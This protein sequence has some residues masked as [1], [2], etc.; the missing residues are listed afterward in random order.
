L[1]L[2]SQTLPKIQLPVHYDSNSLL[3]SRDS[4]TPVTESKTE[5]SSRSLK[6]RCPFDFNESKSQICNDGKIELQG[7]DRVTRHPGLWS[8]GLL[9]LGS[10][11]LS[12]SAPARVWMSMP[13]MVALIGGWHTDSRFMRNMGGTLTTEA[14]DV[15]SNVP[16]L[17]MVTGKQGNPREAFVNLG[18]EIK[19]LNAAVG[20][21][22]A[23]LLV[24]L[25]GRSSM[26]FFR[27][28]AVRL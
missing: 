27:F 7:L 4:S 21:G 13:V 11:A 17:A 20:V 6:V 12:P 8:F 15:T 16:F 24:L 19:V 28:N 3:D 23:G 25:R 1:V 26:S 18:G 2:A 5:S 14:A 10:A 9:G 22:V